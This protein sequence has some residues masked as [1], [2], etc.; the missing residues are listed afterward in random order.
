MATSAIQITEYI[1]EREVSRLTGIRIRTLR[2]W[3]RE[4]KGPPFHKFGGMVRY[5]PEDLER[6]VRASRVATNQGAR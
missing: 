1:D 5:C 3:R 6:W 2:H 4:R